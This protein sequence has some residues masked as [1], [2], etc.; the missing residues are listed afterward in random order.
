MKTIRNL[1]LA[2][3]AALLLAPAVQA[4]D[5]PRFEK[6]VR[7]LSGAKYQGRGYA[8]DGVRKAGKYIAR[9]F[10]KSGVDAVT[11][12]SFTLDINTFSAKCKRM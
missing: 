5:L 3:L 6:M 9:E 7:Q 2:A 4:Q 10:Q 11:L 1:C 12:Q 8:R